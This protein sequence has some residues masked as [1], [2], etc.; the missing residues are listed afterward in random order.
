MSEIQMYLPEQPVG[1]LRKAQ[2]ILSGVNLSRVDVVAALAGTATQ[3]GP[4]LTL[5]EAAEIGRVA[6]G[7][8]K[9]WVSEGSFHKSANEESLFCF[10]VI[11]SSRR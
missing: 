1:L 3:Y 2:S 10:G 5:K 7:T 9:R 4:I 6:Q 8:L 11:A